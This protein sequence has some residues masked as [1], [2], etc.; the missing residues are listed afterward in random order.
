VVRNKK[1]RGGGDFGGGC[2]RG[3]IGKE[4]GWDGD[5]KG[6]DKETKTAEVG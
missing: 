6:A 1:V 4:G 3:G 5:E 2:K